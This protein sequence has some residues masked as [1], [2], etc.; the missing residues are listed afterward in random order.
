MKHIW[1]AYVEKLL[2]ENPT[3]RKKN[4]SPHYRHYTII[5][6]KNVGDRWVQ[7]IT[8]ERFRKIAEH[9]LNSAK[10]AV[11]AGEGF[12]FPHCGKIYVKRIQ[13]DFRSKNRQVDWG[14]T[15]KKNSDFDENGKRIYKKLYY[16]S[17]DDYLRVAWNKADITGKKWYEF[18]PA[19]GKNQTGFK[20][21]LGVANAKDPL[22]KFRYVFNPL[23]DIVK[24]VV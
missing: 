19:S 5:I 24:E 10:N 15:M 21:E 8:Y 6:Q 7:I 3:Y 18:V 17:S 4:T 2:K 9:L 12:N 14:K 1:L 20:A 13:R 16:F 22:L 11:I 23:K